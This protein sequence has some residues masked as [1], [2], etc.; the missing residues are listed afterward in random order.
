MLYKKDNEMRITHELKSQ[1]FIVTSILT[2]ASS[3][4]LILWSTDQQNMPQNIFN[5]SIKYLNNTLA[6]RK[7]LTKWAIY[8]SSACFFRLKT[9]TLQ[10]IVSSCTTYL[11]EGRYTWRHNSL[12]L[13]L[14]KTLSSLSKCSHYADLQS[15]L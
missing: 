7:N 6:T 11:E 15:F 5:F 4:K 9:E 12:L 13:H 10:H 1:G 3:R 2:H 14:A 8:H